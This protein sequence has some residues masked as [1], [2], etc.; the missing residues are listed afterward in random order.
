MSDYANIITQ[1]PRTPSVPGGV[2]GGIDWHGEPPWEKAMTAGWRKLDE[3]ETILPPDDEQVTGW[4]YAQ[5]P[6]RPDYAIESP[7]IEA[8]P[9]VE[10]YPTPEVLIPRIDTN[11]HVIGT[12][13]IFADADNH[14]VLVIDTASPRRA[15]AVQIAEAVAKIASQASQAAE[16]A[17]IRGKAANAG[18]SLPAVR[19]ELVRLAALVEKLIGGAALATDSK[20]G[21][22]RSA[23]YSVGNLT[24]LFLR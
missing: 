6:E 16:A 13:R 15:A 11:G 14:P 3:R 12:S 8:V 17:D 4:Q 10:I 7:V 23:S 1:A 22:T 2:Y 18:N 9:V 21:G 19:A 24:T 20:N 5:D